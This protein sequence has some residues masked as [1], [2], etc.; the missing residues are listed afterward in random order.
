[1]AQSTRKSANATPEPLFQSGT[2]ARWTA[3]TNRDA[4]LDGKFLYAVRTTG[5][6]CRPACPSRRPR[7]EN[8]VF[9]D[10]SKDAKRA[11]FRPC[12][13]CRPL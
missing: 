5:V 4:H 9:F 1:M 10:T 3:V 12:K 7:A 13:R 11:G 8:V 6:Y 2:D